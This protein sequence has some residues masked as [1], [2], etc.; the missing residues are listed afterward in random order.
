MRWPLFVALLLAV[1]GCQAPSEEAV[2]NEPAPV[3]AAENVP[4]APLAPTGTT[5]GGV[6]I[7]TAG[8]GGA[9]PV[10]GSESLGGAGGGGV[11]QA[12]KDRARQAAG[13]AS[14]MTGGAVGGGE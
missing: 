9:A 14:G 6:G 13:Q 1:V 5:G 10:T 7:S 4:Q 3:P 11:Q 2:A 8:A 12:A